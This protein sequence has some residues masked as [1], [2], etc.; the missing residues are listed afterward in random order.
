M[1]YLCVGRGIAAR[2]T[3]I[4]TTAG[5]SILT[6]DEWRGTSIGR[7]SFAL[8]PAVIAQTQ[9][10]TAGKGGI[11]STDL[12]RRAGAII[13]FHSSSHSACKGMQ[14][15]QSRW[16]ITSSSTGQYLNGSTR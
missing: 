1:Q 2:P 11:V 4:P 7:M 16:C 5:S 14:E 15:K 9:P 13:E 12:T 3:R 8:S 6:V 10:P